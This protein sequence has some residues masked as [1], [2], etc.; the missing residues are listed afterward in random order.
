M[1]N[2]IYPILITCIFS[3]LIR[4]LLPRGEKS[5]FYH[6]LKFLI[7]L[8]LI[9][10]VSS[11]LFSLMEKTGQFSFEVERFAET[12]DTAV[13]E[14]KILAESLQSMEKAVRETFPEEEIS[15][16]IISDEHNIP[17][18]IRLFCQC[19]EKG[20]EISAFLQENFS[21]LT[22]FTTQGEAS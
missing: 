18:G 10:S 6:P 9:L 17:T 22:T 7:S 12:S 16:E 15:L 21:L 4:A 19:E 14:E 8:I 20:R 13:Y 2:W 11:P 3:I 5:P 1:K